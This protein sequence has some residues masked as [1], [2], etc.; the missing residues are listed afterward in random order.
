VRETDI[1]D[2]CV[3]LDTM[4]QVVKIDHNVCFTFCEQRLQLSHS[5]HI[6]LGIVECKVADL[7]K[8]KGYTRMTYGRLTFRVTSA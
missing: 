4:V 5:H 2:V 7:K 6:V 3:T 8:D 1:D